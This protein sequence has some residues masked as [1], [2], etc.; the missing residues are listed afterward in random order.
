MARS[1]RPCRNSATFAA[2]FATVRDLVQTSGAYAG[3][4]WHE[5]K[6]D[7]ADG[8]QQLGVGQLAAQAEDDVVDS[9][10]GD[11]EVLLAPRAIEQLDARQ[12]VAARL[13]Q[14]A[15]HGELDRGQRDR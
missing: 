2:R 9:A 15:Q 6:P 10:L 8:L 4:R 12:R 1:R 14:L 3:S 5:A 7:A 13:D 11:L